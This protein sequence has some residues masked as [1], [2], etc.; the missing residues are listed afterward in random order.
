VI[1]VV[2]TRGERW[3]AS[4]ILA[5]QDGLDGHIAFIRRKRDEGVVVDGGP[6]HDPAGLVTD[7][8]V[9]LALLDVDSLETARDLIET[10]PVVRTGAFGYRLYAW[11]VPPLR[12]R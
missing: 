7:E 9:G 10:D 4:Q 11:D 3:N 1:A 2:F 8:L 12:R 6:F 5:E